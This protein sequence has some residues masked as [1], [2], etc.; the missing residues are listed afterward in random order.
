VAE[1]E[2]ARQV[3]SC[4]GLSHTNLCFCPRAVGGTVSPLTV[5]MESKDVGSSGAPWLR[6]SSG[7]G[8]RVVHFALVDEWELAL[9][10]ADCATSCHAR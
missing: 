6:E 3:G 8:A 9:C 4:S 10:P 2:D 1:W 7:C 5:D